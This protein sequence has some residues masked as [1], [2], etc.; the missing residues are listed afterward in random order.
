MLRR[1]VDEKGEYFR[2]VGSVYVHG[3]MDGEAVQQGGW[4]SED[5]EIW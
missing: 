2:I 1:N 5:L 3:I 4:V